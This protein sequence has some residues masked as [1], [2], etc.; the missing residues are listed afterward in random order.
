MFIDFATNHWKN[1]LDPEFYKHSVPSGLSERLRRMRCQE[2]D[3]A[4]PRAVASGCYEQLT[5]NQTA[6]EGC[7]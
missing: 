4:E 1:L 6:C 3:I 5:Q 7:E 2:P